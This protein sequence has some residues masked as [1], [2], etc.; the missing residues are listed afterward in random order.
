MIGLNRKIDYRFEL[1]NNTDIPKEY[2]N[3]KKNKYPSKPITSIVILSIIIIG[4]IFNKF[5]I[6]HDPVYMDLTN[7][8]SSPSWQF[9]FGTDTMGR[10]IFSMVWYGGR[11]SL[12]IGFFATMISTFIAIFYGTVSGLATDFIDEIMMRITEIFLSI[13]NILII[14]FMQAILG[15]NNVISISIVIGVTSWMSISKVVRTEVRQLRNEEYVMYAVY[16]KASIWHLI[17]KHLLPRV[18]PSIMFM[19]VMNIRSAI[20]SEAT[21]S[22][23][24]LGL[25]LEIISWGSMLS[26]SEKALLTNSWWIIII[27]GLFL[28]TTIVCIANIGNYIRKKSNL[29]N[30]YI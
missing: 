13:P 3:D 28:T 23:L 15:N 17:K 22:F 1:A 6:N 30:S 27:P 2:I 11:V 25:P 18:I 4:C 8:N 9:Y 7:Y 21:L 14:I 26:L 29:K 12:F 20:V 19:V 10:D 16:M 5:I 24:G